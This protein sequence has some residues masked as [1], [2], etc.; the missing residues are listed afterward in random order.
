MLLICSEKK[1][2]KFDLC[3]PYAQNNGNSSMKKM[4]KSVLSR[5]QAMKMAVQEKNGNQFY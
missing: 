1:S 3:Y 2:R 4:N 5:I